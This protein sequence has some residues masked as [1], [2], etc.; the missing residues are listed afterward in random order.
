MLLLKQGVRLP[1]DRMVVTYF[2]VI[3]YRN[4]RNEIQRETGIAKEDVG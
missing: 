1:W 3:A 4:N 2:I